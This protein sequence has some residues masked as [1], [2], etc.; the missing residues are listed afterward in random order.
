M[1]LGAA[2]QSIR[3]PR[4]CPEAHTAFPR[5]V[6]I[7][8]FKQITPS[9][10]PSPARAWRRGCLACGHC[11]CGSRAYGGKVNSLELRPRCLRLRLVATGLGSHRFQGDRTRTMW[12]CHRRELRSITVSRAL[13]SRIK[14]RGELRLAGPH[15]ESNGD[16]HDEVSPQHLIERTKRQPAVP[17][18]GRDR[19]VLAPGHSRGEFVRRDA[20]PLGSRK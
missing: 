11:A 7:P 10:P 15:T 3:S 18:S 16:I 20:Q 1:S 12:P 4:S 19:I 17:S 2:A 9:P 8:D 14:I 13:N 5:L 6:H